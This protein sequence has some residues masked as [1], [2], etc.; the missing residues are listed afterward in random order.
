[1][2]VGINLTAHS[3][4][5]WE[6][7]FDKATTK[8]RFLFTLI[9]TLIYFI[10]QPLWMQIISLYAQ[11]SGAM[12]EQVIAEYIGTVHFVILYKIIFDNNNSNYNNN[13]NNNNHNNNNNNNN[14]N[15]L[16]PRSVDDG[17]TVL[18]YVLSELMLSRL[19]ET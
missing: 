17:E 3:S 11:T 16:K 5:G 18:L 9:S 12:G 19:K 2:I 8:Q 1:M 15:V 7:Q 14:N 6:T 13:N 10:Y 4:N